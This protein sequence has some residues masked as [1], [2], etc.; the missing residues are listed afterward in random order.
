MG[1]VR[2]KRVMTFR[3]FYFWIEMFRFPNKIW[4]G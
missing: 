4:N 3:R 2:G 1:P